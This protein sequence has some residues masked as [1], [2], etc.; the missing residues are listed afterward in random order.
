MESVFIFQRTLSAF[1]APCDKLLNWHQKKRDHK[2][3][4]DR[5]AQGGTVIPRSLEKH[6]TERVEDEVSIQWERRKAR[7]EKTLAPLNRKVRK[8]GGKGAVKGD[9]E[10]P[11]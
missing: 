2:S 7:G 4:G 3:D 10:A 8:N 6:V 1:H 9:Q 5:Q 11:S